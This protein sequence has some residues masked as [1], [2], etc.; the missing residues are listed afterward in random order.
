MSVTK[1]L[2]RDYNYND[3]DGDHCY[4]AGNGVLTL[5]FKE[6]TD[7]KDPQPSDIRKRKCFTRTHD[8]GWTISAILHEDYFVWVNE[9]VAIHPKYGYLHGD[10]EHEVVA[11][12]DKAFKRFV[13]SH[14]PESWDYEDI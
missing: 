11:S 13:K 3:F 14:P 12:S 8:S 10:F 1:Q 4:N 9:F 7:L 2:G 5:N 6:V